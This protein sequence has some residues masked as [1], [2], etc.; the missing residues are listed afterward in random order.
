MKLR[1]A[2]I[3]SFKLA[4][5]F[6]PIVIVSLLSALLMIHMHYVKRDV[7][8]LYEAEARYTNA[9]R[10][11]ASHSLSE[12]LRHIA[13]LECFECHS[14]ITLGES[15]YRITFSHM[16]HIE[17]GDHCSDCHRDIKQR[18][19]GKPY[20]KHGAVPM[21]VCLECHDD[22][23]APKK[24]S[25]CHARPQTALPNTHGQDWLERHPKET[26]DRQ[27]CLDCHSEAFCDLCH[28][29]RKPSSHVKG[30]AAKHGEHARKKETQCLQCHERSFCDS[31]HIVRKPSSHIKPDFMKR[32]GKLFLAGQNCLMCHSSS[33]CD[34]CHGIRMPHPKGYERK[35]NEAK[36]NASLCMRCHAQ[37]WCDACHGLPMPHPKDYRRAHAKVK[38]EEQK[39]CERCHGK[40]ACDACHG[41]PL[42][43]PEGFALKHKDVASF[44]PKS[45]CFKCHKREETCAVCHGR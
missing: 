4:L 5:M 24:C 3:M 13:N 36:I 11:S 31:C 35:H 34:S 43:H 38:K 23:R 25:L 9:K 39:I 27:Q 29:P 2:I 37:S 15:A 26:K 8:R 1:R 16:K 14:V 28:K 20:P 12:R 18:E 33:F 45:V 32:H 17:R 19:P 42:P 21:D 41:V 40:N 44:D 22:K 10:I 6:S 30:F 7:K